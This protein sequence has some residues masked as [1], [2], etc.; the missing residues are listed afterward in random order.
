MPRI[1]CCFSN[2][3]ETLYD[4]MWIDLLLILSKFL[5]GIF[6]R[7]QLPTPTSTV[8]YW[9]GRWIRWVWWISRWV[10]RINTDPS[11]LQLLVRAAHPQ[12]RPQNWQELQFSLLILFNL[13]M[14]LSGISIINSGSIL[15]TGSSL[16]SWTGM[17]KTPH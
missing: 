2:I 8:Y 6:I 3:L 9:W 1:L 4:F 12:C 5:F 11:F 13:I 17:M 16:V 7:R 15:A 10:G 14:S